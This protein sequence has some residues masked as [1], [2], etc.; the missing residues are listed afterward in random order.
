MSPS[1]E[2]IPTSG[3]ERAPEPLSKLGPNGT[4]ETETPEA[5]AKSAENNSSSS[6]GNNTRSFRFLLTLALRKAQTAV[7]LDN[8]GH[9]E[10]A[11]RTYREAISMLGLVLNRTNEEDGRQRL[12]HFRQTYS[13]RVS[14]LSSLRPM[15]GE[16]AT[17]TNANSSHKQQTDASDDSLTKQQPKETH[18]QD[19]NA[20]S[21][22]NSPIAN[23]G[24]T[25]RLDSQSGKTRI[26][27][28]MSEEPKLDGAQSSDD[29]HN[30]SA[31]VSIKA[32]TTA[33]VASESPK[34]ADAKNGGTG[35]TSPTMY[36]AAQSNAEVAKNASSTERNADD[37]IVNSATDDT[38]AEQM[39]TAS[40]IVSKP[41]LAAASTDSSP[42]KPDSTRPVKEL[43]LKK[44]DRDSEKASRRQSVKNQRS[45]PAMFGIGLKAKSDKPAP[46]VPNLPITETTTSTLGR[47]IFGALRSNSSSNDLP[48]SKIPSVSALSSAVGATATAANAN[49]N[50][51]ETGIL[52]EISNISETQGNPQPEMPPAERTS[53]TADV[54]DSRS[55]EYG[56]DEKINT[57]F[58]TGETLQHADHGPGL[59]DIPPP[60]PA[61]D[62]APAFP[63][64]Y[65]AQQ[66]LTKEQKR[67]SN[68]AHRLAGLFRRKPSIPDI[69]SPVL[70]PKTSVEPNKSV[71][72]ML[73]SPSQ[74]HLMPKDRRLSASASTPN[75]IE[76]AA[77]AASSDQP[78]LA[79]YAAAERG[80][81]PPMPAPPA[82]RPSLSNT[83]P[84][85]AYTEGRLS[86]EEGDY[87]A[88]E[89]EGQREFGISSRQMRSDSDTSS[90]ANVSTTPRMDE[91]R[92]KKQHSQTLRPSLR[93]ATKSAMDVLTFVPEDGPVA[94]MPMSAGVDGSSRSRKSSV[95]TS[96]SQ[97]AIRGGPGLLSGATN[98]MINGSQVASTP[99][100]ASF[101]GAQTFNRPTLT[102][103][104]EDQRLD[105]FEPSFGTFH[106]DLGPAPL[107]TSPLSALWFINTL[108]R[109]MVTSG[110]HLTPSLYVPRR[111]WYQSGIRITAI[112]TK[113]GVL[114]QLTQSFSSLGTFLA[115]PDIDTLFS[116]TAPN[117][118]T[119]HSETVPWE[120]EDPRSRNSNSKDEL[121]KACV[122]LHHW[123]NNFE[124]V[125]ENSRR[126]LGR[127]LK[128]I[129]SA[130]SPGAEATASVSVMSVP[131][132]TTS[133]ET[134][135]ASIVH[136]PAAPTVGFGD[137][138]HFANASLPSLALSN[139]DLAG[140][141]G[142]PVSPLSPPADP[143]DM[144]LPE[145]RVS[146]T[147]IP[148]TPGGGG[149]GAQS[150]HNMNR[151]VLNKDQMSNSRFKGL[152][153]LGKSVDKIYSNI[154]KEKLDDTSTY[155]AALQRMFEA[156]MVLEV[157]MNYFS[158]VASDADM[159]GW[160]TEVPQSPSTLAN[161]RRNQSR[162]QGGSDAGIRG[163]MASPLAAQATVAA[164]PS[165]SSINS[166]SER[167]SSNTSISASSTTE[168]KN[169][170]RSNYFG[171]RQS[172]S[173]GV[174]SG[175]GMRNGGSKTGVKPR[176]ESFS[177]IPMI[178]PA[179]PM[180]TGSHGNSGRFVLAQSPIKNP[181]SY[182]QQGKGRA[183]G[184]IYARLVRIAEWLNQVLLAW[185]VRDL[186][187]LYAK[188]IK[189]LREW[190]VE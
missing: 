70:P 108:H 116:S 23:G 31:V 29:R 8:G 54:S 17:S 12:L 4:L 145:K 3:D 68:A 169:R 59:S 129:N 11:I 165:A 189:R 18:H 156:A 46:P 85:A 149:N 67:Q 9:I 10:E 5:A 52:P 167:K 43:K 19:D 187:V 66:T 16:S 61:K 163:P 14:V 115:L 82:L 25:R 160:F 173:G 124:D 181:L 94:N 71:Y 48:A 87:E 153:K 143:M 21:A 2:N 140:H 152:G 93:I 148:M 186:Q 120:S 162:G 26:N 27:A 45:L 161:K 1:S 144:R 182:V 74:M 69:R 188:Y 78:S 150:V 172:G 103:I 128:Y 168:K 117:T 106:L 113:L 190:V 146:D 92:H 111:L 55:A 38:K 180:A 158:R 135:N 123:L 63:F 170:R 121:H 37:D 88:K 96:G 176:G 154:Q 166:L 42:S 183:P 86:T 130:S 142:A 28:T 164:E 136:M 33:A 114:A 184:V 50:G 132:S 30:H 36:S 58:D 171:Q 73:Q 97:S 41:A 104:E 122:A 102:D 137:N 157:V 125:L 64:R 56:K 89:D 185:V 151:D 118:D 147:S 83:T 6:G 99:L 179:M 7:T 95:A 13:D 62:T 139:S 175:E 57:S 100:T 20:S 34:Y 22:A 84:A 47:R 72:G 178:A 107:K 24:I 80:D 60:T 40:A 39:D 75:L 134:L 65:P 101:P 79:V 105:M 53:S 119:R 155:A 90:I 177:T 141:Q 138:N 110:A 77:A 133:H 126:M 32:A 98:S 131:A 109:S 112:E 174:D 51:S 159:A 81:I 15:A 91:R 49:A 44:K 76:A 127:K 35:S